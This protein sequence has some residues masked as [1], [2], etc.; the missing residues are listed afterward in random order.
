V[1][2]TTPITERLKM[3]LGFQ[4][5]NLFNHLNFTIPQN[6]INDGG[7]GL[8]KNNAYPGRVIQYSAKFLF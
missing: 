2:K 1:L 8:I 6:N 5:F 3:Q 7:F 4:F